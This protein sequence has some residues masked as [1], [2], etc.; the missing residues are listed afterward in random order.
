MSQRASV[1]QS[2]CRGR[3]PA[4][5]RARF[6]H[7]HTVT[8]HTRGHKVKDMHADIRNRIMFRGSFLGSGPFCVPSFCA[9][10]TIK[11]RTG[12]IQQTGDGS[13]ELWRP[14][15]GSARVRPETCTCS[16]HERTPSACRCANP[17]RRQRSHRPHVGT[18]TMQRAHSLALP[19]HETR[20]RGR[21]FA[22][23]TSVAARLPARQE[24]AAA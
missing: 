1:R 15:S 10:Y 21:L 2:A 24:H 20:G 4:R 19:E 8:P 16:T 9:S 17:S 5:A 3:G 22:N 11:R 12:D 7:T 18:I 6:V 23:I 13:Q 14:L